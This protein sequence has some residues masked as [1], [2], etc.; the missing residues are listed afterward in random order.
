MIPYCYVTAASEQDTAIEALVRAPIIG[1]DIEGAS[2]YRYVDR[3]CLIQ[4]SDA[5]THYIFDPLLLNSIAPLGTILEN[6]SILKIVHGADYDCLALKRDFG[7]QVGPLFDTALAARA[8]GL[9]PYSLQALVE[10]FFAVP[11]P[12]T[13]QKSDWSRRPLSLDQ[14]AYAAGDTA[15][16]LRLHDI[17]K[18]EA[19]QRG[20]LSQIEEECRVIETLTWPA[21]PFDRNDYTRIKGATVLPVAVQRILRELV[22]LRD[23]IA[24]EEDRPP[25]RIISHHDLFTLSRAEPR[26]SKQLL[27]L[28]AR[29]RSVLIRHMPLWLK[30]IEIGLTTTEPFPGTTKSKRPHLTVSQERQLVKL[31]NWRNQ[32]AIDE[33]VEPAM[34]MNNV[35]LK[36]VVLAHPME[37]AALLPILRGW[38]S[39]RYGQTLVNLIAEPH[40]PCPPSPTESTE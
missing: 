5:H 15:Y 18:L 19:E 27:G 37:V 11:F 20:R 30:A 14:L 28:F 21:K 2:L 9:K 4:I 25:F 22:A 17:L 35:T 12:K 29:P 6:R 3:V 24:R 1:I 7:F 38:Q 16:L 34:I 40:P 32:Q 13:H 10:R 33:G 31:T 23:R 26:D 8:T 36:A 39:H